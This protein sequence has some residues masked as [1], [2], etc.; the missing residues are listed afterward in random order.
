MKQN[1]EDK[2]QNNRAG[3]DEKKQQTERWHRGRPLNLHL[4]PEMEMSRASAWSWQH[5]PQ[6]GPKGP[7]RGK[8]R[9]DEGTG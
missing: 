3:I 4:R 8:V 5:K 9:V 7:G 6:D 2:K 1:P